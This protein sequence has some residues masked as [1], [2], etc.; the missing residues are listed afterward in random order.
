MVLLVLAI[1]SSY[2]SY[3]IQTQEASH[4][5]MTQLHFRIVLA[6]SLLEKNLQDNL[7]GH[8]VIIGRPSSQPTPA[9]LVERYF[10]CLIPPSENKQLPTRRCF[11]CSHTE[12]KTNR[13]K[14]ES[15]YKCSICNVGL[16]F[17]PCFRIYDTILSF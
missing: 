9:R 12:K 11:V 6:R 2:H 14:H 17:D 8:L 15:R 5:V 13:T 10:P 3:K 4:D 1:L 7:S 16:C